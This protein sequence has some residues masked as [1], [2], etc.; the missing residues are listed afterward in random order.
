MPFDVFVLSLGQAA[1]LEYIRGRFGRE[2]VT[3][4]E[5]DNRF[6]T[7]TWKSEAIGAERSGTS[8]VLDDA[9]ILTVT[10]SGRQPQERSYNTSGTA[11]PHILLEQ[12]LARMLEVEKKE[13]VVDVIR[14]DGRIVPTYVSEIELKD[15][16]AEEDISYMVKLLPLEGRDSF[17]L[18]YLNDRKHILGSRVRE[19]V[20]TIL[21]SVEPQEA[22]SLFPER[23]EFILQSDKLKKYLDEMI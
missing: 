15:V 4:F 11:I 22:A 19:D 10:I 17:E 21:E 12:L 7:F 20:Y 2:E 23:A 5:S 3:S 1:G 6:K 9:G 13:M 14:S 18:V 8:M 16:A